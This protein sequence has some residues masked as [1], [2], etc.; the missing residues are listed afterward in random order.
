MINKWTRWRLPLQLLLICIGVIPFLIACNARADIPTAEVPYVSWTGVSQ[1]VRPVWSPDGTN[2]VL[3]E[4]HPRDMS[5]AQLALYSVKDEQLTPLT[6]TLGYYTSMSWSPDSSRLVVTRVNDRAYGKDNKGQDV[7]VIDLSTKQIKSI[8]LGDGVAWAPD[9]Q[10]IAIYVGPNLNTHPGQFEINIVQPDGILLKTIPLPITP[11]LP[12][13]TPAPATP[14]PGQ[15]FNIPPSPSE[16]SFGGMSWSPDSQ[17]IVLSIIRAPSA[18]GFMGDLHVVSVAGN[19]YH[20]ITSEGLNHEPAWS[21]D[22]RTIAY[23]K[24]TQLSFGS[25]YLIRPDG[26]CPSLLSETITASSLSWSPDGSKIAYADG[27]SVYILDIKKKLASGT[28]AFNS[29][30]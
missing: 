24:G 25:L 11:T 4:A 22:G 19:E 27:N 1:F 26:S 17:Q 3:E 14:A 10:H 30:P 21:S 13:P 9:G 12:G 7:Q 16:D 6:Y 8:G 29:C 15:L 28:T 5:I 23:I 18:G 20:K 2:L